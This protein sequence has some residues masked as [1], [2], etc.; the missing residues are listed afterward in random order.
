MH[1][2][3][4]PSNQTWSLL[5]FSFKFWLN[6]WH[7]ICWLV[8]SWRGM[9][10]WIGLK[11]R[12][13]FLRCQWPASS[14]TVIKVF[15]R[16]LAGCKNISHTWLMLPIKCK[17]RSQSGKDVWEILKM[18]PRNNY[19]LN[20]QIGRFVLEISKSDPSSLYFSCLGGSILRGC[21]LAGLDIQEPT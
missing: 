12:S 19:Q 18:V 13:P 9:F 17:I 21:K 6:I 8:Y 2:R 16:L 10:G 1:V 5:S 15:E 11:T 14:F 7:W 20:D 3:L 4:R